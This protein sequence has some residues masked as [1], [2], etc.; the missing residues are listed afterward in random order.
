MALPWS[1]TYTHK[2]SPK[3]FTKLIF[4]LSSQRS[5]IKH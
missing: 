3:N 1:A 2:F 5:L 4:F